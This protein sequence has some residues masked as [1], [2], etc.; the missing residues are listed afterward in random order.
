MANGLF[1]KHFDS[2]SRQGN[3][4]PHHRFRFTLT[5]LEEFIIEVF[6]LIVV[7]NAEKLR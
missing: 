7:F 6:K 1:E 2:Y 3:I 4:F 5:D